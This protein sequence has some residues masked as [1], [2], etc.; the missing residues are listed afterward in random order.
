MIVPVAV[1][2]FPV[3][4]RRNTHSVAH[5]YFL[6]AVAMVSLVSLAAGRNLRATAPQRSIASSTMSAR[7]AA[8]Y[9]TFDTADTPAL[10]A[11]VILP[12]PR[13]I[14]GVPPGLLPDQPAPGSQR[15]HYIR[16]PPCA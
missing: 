11:A 1:A 9:T 10:A 3:S 4:A 8:S 13:V 7:A 6:V 14:H 2:G 5:R 15:F 16:P 12:A